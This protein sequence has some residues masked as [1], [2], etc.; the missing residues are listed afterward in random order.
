MTIPEPFVSTS[1]TS[2]TPDAT[3]TAPTAPPRATDFTPPM[4]KHPGR[5]SRE[6][7]LARESLGTSDD[8]AAQGA[9][10]ENVAAGDELVVLF[11]VAVHL[12]GE[13]E[14]ERRK[15]GERGDEKRGCDRVEGGKIANERSTVA[16]ESR[17]ARP[18]R[19]FGDSCASAFARGE[20][21]GVALTMIV[22]GCRTTCPANGALHVEG[23]G[24]KRPGLDWRASVSANCS[25]NRLLACTTRRPRESVRRGRRAVAA[26]KRTRICT[27][28]VVIARVA[29]GRRAC[30]GRRR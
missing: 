15:G 23:R 8:A 28:S 24:P 6:N 14:G 7:T 10:H 3:L 18:D 16:M 21:K 25:E 27:E 19:G 22:P 12:R 11:A 5:M 1:A 17:H 20:G 4:V 9:P 2:G 26:A 29:S 30:A 13:G